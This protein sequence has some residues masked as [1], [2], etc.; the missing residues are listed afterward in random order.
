MHSVHI[1]LDFEDALFVY[2]TASRIGFRLCQVFLEQPTLRD[3]GMSR[4][5]ERGVTLSTSHRPFGEC[6][7]VFNAGLNLMSGWASQE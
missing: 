3:S 6:M 1:F 5:A 4:F 7:Y 2:S